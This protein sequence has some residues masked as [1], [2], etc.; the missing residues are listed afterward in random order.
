MMVFAELNHF[1]PFE[2]LRN[3]DDNSTKILF[4]PKLN[5]TRSPDQNELRKNKSELI[6]NLIRQLKSNQLTH[7]SKEPIL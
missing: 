6:N 7:I 1:D 2:F 4:D 5:F 3:L